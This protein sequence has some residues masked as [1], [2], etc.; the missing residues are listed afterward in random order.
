MHKYVP[1]KTSTPLPRAVT[2]AHAY[3][4]TVCPRGLIM[5]VHTFI[6][7]YTHAFALLF[8]ARFLHAS[9]RAVAIKLSNN[10][11]DLGIC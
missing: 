7:N 3:N 2:Y 6:H 11:H 9:F 8:R 10:K 4:L 5:Y 1:P